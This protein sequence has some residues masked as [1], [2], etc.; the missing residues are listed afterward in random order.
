MID[1]KFFKTDTAYQGQN[2]CSMALIRIMA[3]LIH[4]SE[5]ELGISP[6]FT[7]TKTTAEIDKALG[8]VSK[9]H[10]TGRAFDLRTWNYSDEQLKK[11]YD[12]LMTNYGHLGAWTKLGNRQLVVHHDSGYGDH[13][14]VQID[15]SFE[16][17]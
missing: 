7:E 9:S 13:F 17:T 11:I 10:Q 3:D 14:H 5:S 8:R 6:V 2:Q 16:V 12:Y 1:K 4:Y 15:R